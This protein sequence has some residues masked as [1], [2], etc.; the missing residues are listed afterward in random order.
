LEG[1]PDRTTVQLVERYPGL[2]D[3]QQISSTGG[4]LPI[5]S[6]DGREL[7][8]T[9]AS[10]PRLQAVSIQ[11]GDTLVAGRP[12]VLFDSAFNLGG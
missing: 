9:D 1:V 8:F 7:F 3:R 2:G 5:W 4:Y 6:A 11:P 10:S 12:K